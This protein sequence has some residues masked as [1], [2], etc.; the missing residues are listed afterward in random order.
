MKV[1]SPLA[2]SA[3]GL[4]AVGTGISSPSNHITDGGA[5]RLSTSVSLLQVRIVAS[6]QLSLEGPRDV[7]MMVGISGGRA[8]KK[9]T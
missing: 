8:A 6:S 5:K 7:T 1:S 3:M 2:G 4:P 9:S